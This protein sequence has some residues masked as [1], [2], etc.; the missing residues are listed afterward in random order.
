[1]STV[2]SCRDY[3]R[4]PKLAIPKLG[5]LLKSGSFCLFLGAGAS[6]GF[7]LPGWKELIARILDKDDDPEF[8][9]ELSQRSVR[10]LDL[11]LDDI[12]DGGIP[13]YQCVHKA[14][15]RDALPNL[16]DQLSRSPLLLAIAALM[17]GAH[18]GRINSVITFNYD[19]LLEQYI[20][21]LGLTV[22][23]RV[24][25]DQLSTRS[26]AE[27]NYVHGNLPQNFDSRQFDSTSLVLSRKSH[28]RR[29]AHV[30]TGWSARVENVLC[31]KL[32]LFV[33]LSGDDDSMLVTLTRARD[34]I[35]RDEDYIGYW[36]L[37]PDAFARN[38]KRVTEA[39]VCPIPLEIQDIPT[40]LFET[41]Q[42]AAS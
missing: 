28:I 15:Y 37:T 34:Q 32:G 35:N 10:D 38:S 21:M 9:N 27:L 33:G 24:R 29:G 30:D 13:F 1:M 3:A 16:S 2:F 23:R 26:D 7:G 22:C 14:L 25:P 17:T 20:R 12:D 4:T 31:S 42:A 19:D 5:Q 18:R 6:S 8:L 40:F 36:I 41:C 11:L 39:G